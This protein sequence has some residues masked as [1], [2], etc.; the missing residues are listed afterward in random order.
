M[1]RLFILSAIASLLA[2]MPSPS[3]ASANLNLSKSNINRL[4][5]GKP[6]G[7]VVVFEGKN[8]KCP[9]PPETK[10]VPPKTRSK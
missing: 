1:K 2:T 4:C 6:A 8:E 3:W 7:A 10:S 5:Q 9:A